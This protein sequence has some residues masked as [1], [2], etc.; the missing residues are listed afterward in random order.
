MT[1]NVF[2]VLCG[3]IAGL[4]IGLGGV[5]AGEPGDVSDPLVSESYVQG[6]SSFNL[7]ELAPGHNLGVKGGSEV[8]VTSGELKVRNAE[9]ALIIDLTQGTE[10][11]GLDKLPRNHLLLVLSTTDADV[12]LTADGGAS[13]YK[14]GF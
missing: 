13:V 10:L 11:A 8:L 3:L 4:A 1:R 5:I 12:I 7:L 14:R 6:M 9:T 2:L